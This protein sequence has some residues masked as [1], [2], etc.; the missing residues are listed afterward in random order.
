M[1]TTAQAPASPANTAPTKRIEVK[2][3]TFAYRDIGTGAGAP[4]VLLN[5]FRATM[6]DWDPELV[7]RLATKRRVIVFDNVGVGLTSGETPASI[8][9]MADS[10]IDLVDAL[11]LEQVDLLGWSMGGMVS[12]A[13]S[14]AHPDRVRRVI[15]AGSSPAGVPNSP[16]APAKVA[17]V[18]T[19][20]SSGLEGLL[21]LFFPE[22]AEGRAAGMAHFGHMSKNRRA[23]PAIPPNKP[24]VFRSQAIAIQTFRKSGGVY[25]QLASLKHRVLLANGMHDVMMPAFDSFAAAQQLSNADL[26]VYPA[27]GHAFLFQYADRF[28]D[29][30][31]AFLDRAD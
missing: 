4:L 23:E 26:I 20:P 30:V 10:A 13:A 18:A 29:D 2:G 31:H 15:V 11:G 28:A 24:K 14:I 9:S 22:T 8:P 16:P 17:E 21:Y 27:A 12:L 19:N 5:R 6:D 3:T 7:D 1:S 25:A